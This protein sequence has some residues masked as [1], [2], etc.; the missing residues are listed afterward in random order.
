MFP[1]VNF[2]QHFK[3]SPSPKVT[4][5]CLELWLSNWLTIF[6]RFWQ[7][8]WCEYL[9]WFNIRNHKW[10]FYFQTF[11]SLTWLKIAWK[12]AVIKR[13]SGLLKRYVAAINRTPVTMNNVGRSFV[14]L[15]AAAE[16][17]MLTVAI[18]TQGPMLRGRNR[19]RE[20]S[21]KTEE[22]GSGLWNANMKE[23]K[24]GVK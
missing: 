10:L 19:G 18:G 17:E 13:S 22:W 20:S 3:V 4:T 6:L 11:V 5:A 9:L 7:C 12:L 21:Q 16:K 23:A 14:V 1:I 8:E 24:G 2:S 15:L